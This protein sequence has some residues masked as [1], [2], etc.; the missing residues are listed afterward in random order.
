M[1]IYRAREGYLSGPHLGGTPVHDLATLDRRRFLAVLAAL[2]APPLVAG[3]GSAGRATDT[4]RLRVGVL[5]IVGAAPLTLAV[6]EGLF[7]GA[8][9]TVTTEPIQ[10]GAV[11]LPALV[12]G[13]LDVLFGN[14]VSTI[15]ARARDLEVVIVAEASRARPDNFS[16]VTLP[17]SP[18]QRATDLAGRT[19][20]VNALNNIAPLTVSA[21]LD[22]EGIAPD[23]LTFVE[24][25]FPDMANALANGRVDAAFLPEPFLSEARR[26]LGVRT[27]LDPCSGPTDGLPIDGY[28]VTADFAEQNP[29]TVRTFRD[30]L[31]QAQRRCADR[32][33]LE[34]LLVSS[35]RIAPETAARISASAYP[36]STDA[37]QVQRV[38]DLMLRFGVITEPVD[39]SAMVIAGG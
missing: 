34:P 26:T 3:C 16:V 38:A 27:I 1:S 29:G 15:A 7:T 25:P 30:A 13:D 17:G 9:L 21:V 12:A 39:V 20:G 33:V 19:I 28:V 24:I 36:T 37:A 31:V 2:A 4:S 11:A 6:E 5:P 8:G 14:H 35:A 10:S 32:A 23:A 22:A 18:V